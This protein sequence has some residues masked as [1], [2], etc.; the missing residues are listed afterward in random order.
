MSNMLPRLQWVDSF[1]F[2]LAETSWKMPAPSPVR[3]ANVKL[4]QHSRSYKRSCLLWKVSVWYNK[5]FEFEYIW[6]PGPIFCLLLGL[7][8]DYAQ[9]VTGQVTEVTCPVIG[10]AQPELSSD[11]AQPI[12]GQVTEVTC[13]VIGR[14]QPEFTPS[15]RQKTSP[16]LTKT[17]S[18][19]HS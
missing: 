7:I 6:A 16:D 12:T 11:C 14:A 3:R 8:S 2:L 9:P 4:C 13:P 18:P 10:Q 15:K 19:N 1:F 5:D 17:V